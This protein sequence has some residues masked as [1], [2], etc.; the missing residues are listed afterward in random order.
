MAHQYMPK[1]F[2]GPTKTLRPPLLQHAQCTIPYVNK[3]TLKH[4]SYSLMVN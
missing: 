1:V 2:H 4:R 3:I